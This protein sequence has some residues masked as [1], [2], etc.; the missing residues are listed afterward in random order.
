MIRRMARSVARLPRSISLFTIRS[1]FF[2]IPTPRWQST[3]HGVSL[4]LPITITLLDCHCRKLHLFC[5]ARFPSSGRACCALLSSP[6]NCFSARPSQYEPEG[7][8]QISRC[9]SGAGG[10]DRLKSQ[11]QREQRQRNSAL[12]FLAEKAMVGSGSSDRFTHGGS[13]GGLMFEH[14]IQNGN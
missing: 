8:A 14:G 2:Y 10:S 9:A 4:R 5:F 3:N 6:R 11:S 7:R 1:S 12:Q 13:P